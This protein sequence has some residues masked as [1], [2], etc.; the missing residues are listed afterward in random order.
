VQTTE[1]H[2]CGL[3]LGQRTQTSTLGVVGRLM[4]HAPTLG[5]ALRDFL[6]NQQR[7]AQ[8]AVP[9]LLMQDDVFVAGYAVYQ[10]GVQALD[11]ICDATL[12]IGFNIV[13]QLSGTLPV[14]VLLAHRTPVN[15]GPYRR[16]FAAPVRFEA[17]QSALVY[18]A[19]SLTLT[20]QGAN[21]ELRR[22]LQEQVRSYW[23]V[24]QPDLKAQVTRI[25]RSRIILGVPTLEEVADCFVPES[26]D[27]EPTAP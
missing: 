15:A 5:M 9:Y 18:P 16:F 3:R 4:Q 13:R 2:D 19:R 1:H 11:Q 24:S 6:A 22:V 17:E 10:P 21:A 14:E 23:A 8:G 25:L 12:A 7:H 27:V 26:S 20:I